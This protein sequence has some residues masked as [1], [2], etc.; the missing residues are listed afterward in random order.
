MSVSP[1]SLFTERHYTDKRVFPITAQTSVIIEEN[2]QQLQLSQEYYMN[3]RAD[4]RS[5]EHRINRELGFYVVAVTVRHL[6]LLSVH[7]SGSI[8]FR[9]KN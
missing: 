8:Y 3:L 2:I 4:I 1:T 5:Q 7:N 6:G 9:V